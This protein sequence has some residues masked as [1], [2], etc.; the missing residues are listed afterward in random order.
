MQ[1]NI[2]RWWIRLGLHPANLNK[3]RQLSQYENLDLAIQQQLKEI[4]PTP[5]S[6]INLRYAHG[7]FH[8]CE[9]LSALSGRESFRILDGR[10]SALKARGQIRFQRGKDGGWV[11]IVGMPPVAVVGK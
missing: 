11:P 3:E 2:R 9:R 10:L 7:I 8:E 5:A 6:W 1:S 4:S